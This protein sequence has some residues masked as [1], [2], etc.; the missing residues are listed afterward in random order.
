V[1]A[2]DGETVV[3]GGLIS[4]RNEKDEAKVPWLGDLPGVGTLFRYR[5]QKKKKT[6]LL[7]ILTPQVVRCRADAD[8]IL[9]EESGKIDWNVPEVLRQNGPHG[10]E[11]VMPGFTPEI[12]GWLRPSPSPYA[13]AG[14]SGPLGPF[15]PHTPIPGTEILPK[16]TPVPGGAPAPLPMPPVIHDNVPVIQHQPQVAPQNSAQAQPPAMQRNQQY[17]APGQTMPAHQVPQAV[18]GNFVSQPASAPYPPAPSALTPAQAA[19]YP[20]GTP[21][22]SYYPASSRPSAPAPGQQPLP[23]GTASPAT[24]N[25]YPNPQ[26]RES[27]QWQYYQKSS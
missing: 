8:R 26:G 9:N 12:P 19:G 2:Q 14:P 24:M 6:E 1:I 20:A 15:D 27:Q 4:R 17:P 10:M 16:P 22:P 25:S 11:P 7:I 13:P 21:T 3:L 23:S 5:Q 18:Q